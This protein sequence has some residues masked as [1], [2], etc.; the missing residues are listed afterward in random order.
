MVFLREAAEH[1]AFG[2]EYGLSAIGNKEWRN[3]QGRI[4][5]GLIQ[6]AAR[7]QKNY[8]KVLYTAA[9]KITRTNLKNTS[10]SLS[11]SEIL[12]LIEEMEADYFR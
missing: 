5:N 3:R 8:R 11:S 6:S 10:F 1:V 9:K 12:A 2:E 7:C 4:A